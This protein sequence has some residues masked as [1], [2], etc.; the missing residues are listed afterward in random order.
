MAQ[1]SKQF[2][3]KKILLLVVLCAVILLLNTMLLNL[4]TGG[5]GLNR[6]LAKVLTEM[7]LFVFSWLMQKNVIFTNG[8][9]TVNET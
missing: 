8:R 7:V 6:Y 4:L 2:Q 1:A 9:K 3:G 5:L